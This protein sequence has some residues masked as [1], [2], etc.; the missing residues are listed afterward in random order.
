MTIKKIKLIE[1][2]GVNDVD[3]R[4]QVKEGIYVDGKPKQRLIWVC[5]FYVKW[6][7]MLRRCYSDKYHINLP[8]YI[9]CSVSDEWLSLSTFK[10]W[11]ET[12][13]WEGKHL[14]KDIL[15]PSNKVYG[16]S[17]CVFVDT[18]VNTFLTDCA[19]ARGE[20]PIG[21]YFNKRDSKFLARCRSVVT[22]KQQHLGYFDTPEEAHQAWLSFKLEQAKILAAGQTDERVAKALIAKYENYEKGA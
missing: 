19:A 22:G 12:Q 10:S 9:G 11:M 3:Y 14:D 6:R 16:P 17:N 2:V 1:G 20:W 4:V 8:T 15:F 21:V 13:D 7:D 5:P 18:K